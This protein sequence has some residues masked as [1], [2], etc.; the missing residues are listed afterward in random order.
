LLAVKLFEC[1][2]ILSGRRLLAQGYELDR[3]GTALMPT[4]LP[5]PRK[6]KAQEIEDTV[7]NVMS[8][9]VKVA[10]AISC[11]MIIWTFWFARG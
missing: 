3:E 4:N 1:G 8:I 6:R 7:M 5:D 10:M 11:A 9:V 2:S